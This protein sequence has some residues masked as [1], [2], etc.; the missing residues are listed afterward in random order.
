MRERSQ[1]VVQ[2]GSHQ[3]RL[4]TYY[5]W[6]TW[7]HKDDQTTPRNV[8]SEENGKY[9][10]TQPLQIPPSPPTILENLESV[11]FCAS[12]TLQNSGSFNIMLFSFF[13]LI[14]EF[15]TVQHWRNIKVVKR[16]ISEIKKYQGCLHNVHSLQYAH[17]YDSISNYRSYLFPHP[18][19]CDL[20]YTAPKMA[21]ESVTWGTRSLKLVQETANDSLIQSLATNDKKMLWGS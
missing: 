13:P 20:C 9:L 11:D 16:R 2:T 4:L 15:H 19:P 7:H 14:K 10:L 17:L 5:T 21:N 18:S 8:I 6:Q 3:T 12:M 1:E